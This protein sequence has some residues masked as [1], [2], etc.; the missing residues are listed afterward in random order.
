M[1]RIF[2]H[3]R[4]SNEVDLLFSTIWEHLNY[5]ELEKLVDIYQ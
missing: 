3:G 5:G 2:D 4:H 1:V